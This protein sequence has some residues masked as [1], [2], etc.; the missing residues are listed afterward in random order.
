[1]K[2]RLTLIFAALVVLLGAMIW[3]INDRPVAAP[4]ALAVTTPLVTPLV[5][6]TTPVAAPTPAAVAP[7]PAPV[8][9][10]SPMVRISM[11]GDLKYVARAGDTV[12]QLAIA[13]LGSDTKEHRDAVI[14][15]NPSLQ[16][17]VDRVLEGQT[18]S[19]AGPS[20][21]EPLRSDI[22]GSSRA[23]SNV[24]PSPE[25]PQP[26]VANTKDEPVDAADKP[27]K[28]SIAPKL[29]YIAQRGDTVGVLAANL[30]G[31]NTPANRETIINANPSLGNDPD[32][33]VAGQTYTIPAPE[34]LAADRNVGPTVVPTTQPEADD[35]ARASV[36]R[37]LRYTATSQ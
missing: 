31:G 20:A 26:P 19:I 23:A 6:P 2:S 30:L 15:A 14:A 7:A 29:K 3:V 33:L 18:Y 25:A 27:V 37:A 5:P 11:A 36:G 22:D 13:L 34:G 9:K 8:A 1:M 16:S 10:S 28:V 32:R 12:S 21:P 24:L 17:D 35:A 4:P